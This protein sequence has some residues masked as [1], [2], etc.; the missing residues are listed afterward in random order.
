VLEARYFEVI[1]HLDQVDAADAE[2]LAARVPS[3]ILNENIYGVD[4]S[5]EA[6]EITQL[7]LWIRSATKGQTLE[8]LSHNIVH[9]N[10][11]VHDAEKHPAGFD[12]RT[13]FPEVFER[14]ESGF[15]CVIGN[16]PWERIKLQ[17]REMIRDSTDSMSKRWRRLIRC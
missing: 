2:E 6:V 15:D 7:A 5:P 13:R 9:G 16:P 3:F 11:L 1:G 12:W 14:E 8:T 4:L 10:S 17:E